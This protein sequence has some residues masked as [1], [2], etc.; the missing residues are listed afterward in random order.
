MRT[1]QRLKAPSDLCTDDWLGALDT[2]EECRNGC[3]VTFKSHREV[4]GCSGRKESD[5]RT[6]K[7]PAPRFLYSMDT[8][9][10]GGNASDTRMVVFG[11]ETHDACYLDDVWEFSVAEA[12]WTEQSAPVPDGRKKCSDL[13]D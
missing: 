1:I 9:S 3:F 5:G 13:L 12:R 2:K 11:G 6:G 8:F 4:S 7:T 10:P